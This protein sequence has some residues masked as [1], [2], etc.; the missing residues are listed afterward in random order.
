MDKVDLTDVNNWPD[1]AAANIDNGFMK[2]IH[3]KEYRLFDGVW[4]E[5]SNPWDIEQYIASANFNVIM[6]PDK[7]KEGEQR[8][9][10][11]QILKDKQLNEVSD[12]SKQPRYKGGDGLDHIDEFARDNSIEDF[13]AAMRF[14]IGK[15][16][17]RLGKK[18]D[19]S[20][21]LYK[22]SD[23]YKR[24]SEVEKKLEQEKGE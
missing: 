12:F 9:E 5:S 22:I 21:E 14:T 4:V 8:I 3:D 7:W 11:I 23:Y 1:G 17:K 16:E 24:W 19:R 2:W 20:K 18:D 6:R 10:E 13:R 15:Y